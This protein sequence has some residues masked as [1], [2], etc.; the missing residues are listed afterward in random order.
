MGGAQKSA[1]VSMASRALKF[2]S[3][4]RRHTRLLGQQRPCCILSHP[5]PHLPVSC[6]QFRRLL[7]FPRGFFLIQIRNQGKVNTGQDQPVMNL[8]GMGQWTGTLTLYD[9]FIINTLQ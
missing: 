6:L 9:I 1:V 5:R 8:L 2:S 4:V 3:P 7:S